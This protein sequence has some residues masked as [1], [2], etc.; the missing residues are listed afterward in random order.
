MS[1]VKFIQIKIII[2]INM[3]DFYSIRILVEKR[4]N[5]KRKKAK[6]GNTKAFGC[7]EQ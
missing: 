3:Y 6:R 5:K 7:I 1:D 4:R 2:I